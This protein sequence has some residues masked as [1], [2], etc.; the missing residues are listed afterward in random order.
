MWINAVGGRVELNHTTVV[1]PHEHALIDYGQMLGR[2]KPVSKEVLQRTQAQFLAL[3]SHGLGVFVDCTPA[4]YGR[5]IGLLQAFSQ[6]S[7]VHIVASTGTFCEQWHH[8]PQRVYSSSIDEL[9]AHFISELNDRCGAIKIAT[10]HEIMHPSEKK[11]FEAA[12]LAHCATGAP[13]VA[14]TTASLGLEQVEFLTSRGVEPSK[15]L[16]SHV[17]AAH[18]PVEYAIAIAETGAYVGFDRI[19]HESHPDDHWLNLIELLDEAGLFSQV[20]ISTDSVQFFQG[21]DDIAAHTYS[22]PDRI[23]QD[24]RAQFESRPQLAGRFGELVTTHPL[25]W[26]TR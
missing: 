14:H 1:L 7:G 18:E 23:F 13:I 4:G 2:E 20:L 8:L 12:S 21:P 11:A 25:T 3:A 10:S 9:A 15:I 17:C 24:F 6:K 26:L 5:D 22:A 19:G 16:V